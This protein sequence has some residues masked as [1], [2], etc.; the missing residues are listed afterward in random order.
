MKSRV[1]RGRAQMRELLEA[2]CKFDVDCRGTVVAWEARRR[3]D[4]EA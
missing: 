4:C 2:C 3:C 1:Q